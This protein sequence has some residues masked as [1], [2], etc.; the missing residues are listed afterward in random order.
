MEVM[1]KKLYIVRHGHTRFNLKDRVQGA[2]DSPLTALGQRQALAAKKYLKDKGVEFDHVFASCQQRAFDTAE[3]IGGKD[4]IMVRDLKEMDFG[5]Y[6]GD[7][8][9]SL[10]PLDTW[11]EEGAMPTGELLREVRQRGQ[12]ALRKI[13]EDDEVN[14]A[15]VVSHGVLIHELMEMMEGN[16]PHK[17]PENCGVATVEYDTDTSKFAVVERWAPEV[18]NED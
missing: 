7:A 11:N 18:S 17:F 2:C 6:E 14:S 5:D 15:L 8:N 3:I 4:W 1:K 9:S 10:P 12:N 16:D 13:V